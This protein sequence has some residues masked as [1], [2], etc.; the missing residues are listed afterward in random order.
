MLD[1]AFIGASKSFLRSLQSEE[2]QLEQSCVQLPII[3]PLNFYYI[4]LP[5]AKSKVK[6][7]NRFLLIYKNYYVIILI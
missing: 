5:P 2:E 6:H 3:P 4:I 7:N 1:S